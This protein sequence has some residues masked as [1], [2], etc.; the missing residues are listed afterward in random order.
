MFV[1]FIQAGRTGPIKIG[2]AID[3]GKRLAVLQTGNHLTLYLL[4]KIKC[5]GNKSAYGL[6]S[7]LHKLFRSKRVRGEWF[8]SNIRLSQVRELSSFDRE[9]FG[10]HEA[11]KQQAKNP[12]RIR[13][14]SDPD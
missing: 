13:Q 11:R 1:Y 6:E 14:Q 4:A 8:S 7:D 10:G 2:V 5:K 9:E 12:K 3:V